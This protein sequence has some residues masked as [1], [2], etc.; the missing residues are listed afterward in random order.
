[1]S[2]VT[3]SLCSGII[4]HQGRI[5][6]GRSANPSQGTHIHTMD[7][8]EMPINLQCMSLDQ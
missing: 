8:L 1:M 2:Q 3:G 6:P 5:H 7:Y 4:G